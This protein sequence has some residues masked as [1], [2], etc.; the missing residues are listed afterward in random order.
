MV[1]VG[2][3]GRYKMELYTEFEVWEINQWKL[4]HNNYTRFIEEH[5]AS[6][7][8]WSDVTIDLVLAKALIDSAMTCC[9]LNYIS[10]LVNSIK[11]HTHTQQ[12]HINTYLEVH[13]SGHTQ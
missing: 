2:G 5:I 7:W 3:G 6:S 8:G 13:A 1:V 11:T 10:V 12:S 9:K 4:Q